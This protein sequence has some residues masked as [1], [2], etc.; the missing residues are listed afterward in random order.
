MNG[1]PIHSCVLLFSLCNKLL[2]FSLF[3]KLRSE[4]SLLL[5]FDRTI[6]NGDTGHIHL[7]EEDLPPKKEINWLK[8]DRVRNISATSRRTGKRYQA[9]LLSDNPELL[10]ELMSISPDGGDYLF[11]DRYQMVDAVI[12]VRIYYL[13]KRSYYDERFVYHF[14]DQTVDRERINDRYEQV[15]GWSF[16]TMKGE[17]VR[18]DNDDALFAPAEEIIEL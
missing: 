6:M 13:D 9:M 3:N 11:H 8:F 18:V 15:K 7:I 12:H 4:K 14:H 5:L 17:Y 16:T 2:L 10:Q 1:I